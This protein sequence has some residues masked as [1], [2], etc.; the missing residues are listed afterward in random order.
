MVKKKKQKHKIRKMN[1]GYLFQ[2]SILTDDHI[3]TDNL[4]LSHSH[5]YRQIK[6]TNPPNVHVLGLWE[7]VHTEM[8]QI[9]PGVW[10]LPVRLLCMRLD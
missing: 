4:I 1:A 6:V 5:L 7:F 10:D 3:R 9:R 2:P 8:I